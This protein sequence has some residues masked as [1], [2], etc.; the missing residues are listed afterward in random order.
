[1]MGYLT[2]LL[3][4]RGGGQ[5]QNLSGNAKAFSLRM[6][7]IW[8]EQWWHRDC[9]RYVLSITS[10]FVF[11]WH[12]KTPPKLW[13]LYDYY[14]WY[15][16]TP[17]CHQVPSLSFLHQYPLLYTCV[18]CPCLLEVKPYNKH[19]DRQC[20]IQGTRIF[21]WSS[22]TVRYLQ[23]KMARITHIWSIMQGCKV[24]EVKTKKKCMYLDMCF[25]FL[26]MLACVFLFSLNMSVGC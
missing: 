15:C 17:T 13:L 21:Y 16:T 11:L 1:M 3:K 24:V 8:T 4:H 5:L 7:G 10:F 2:G 6:P 18:S 23:Y 22:A 14:A 20:M 9:Y 12:R 19:C 26:F 25:N